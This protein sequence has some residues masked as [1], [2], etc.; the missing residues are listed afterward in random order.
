MVTYPPWDTDE[1]DLL[2]LLLGLHLIL[3]ALDHLLNHLAAYRA[4]L[5]GSEVAVITVLK[6]NAYFAGSLHLKLIK[7]F[8]CLGYYILVRHNK[9]LLF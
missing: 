9:V 2:G 3:V 5:T 1:T 8:L 4:C 7:C 6:V